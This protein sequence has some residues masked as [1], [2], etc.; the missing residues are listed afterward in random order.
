MEKSPEQQLELF[1][2]GFHG[3]LPLV[4]TLKGPKPLPRRLTFFRHEA[5]TP[6]KHLRTNRENGCGQEIDRDLAL[7]GGADLVGTA[8]RV[9]GDHGHRARA[10]VRM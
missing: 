8:Y 6:L 2:H 4:S 10:P 7:E 5:A 9:P 3:Q 1:S